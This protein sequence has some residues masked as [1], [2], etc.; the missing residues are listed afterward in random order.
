M[1]RYIASNQIGKC[2]SPNI[3]HTNRIKQRLERPDLK[4][5][6]GFKIFRAGYPFLGPRINK[7]GNLNLK[8]GETVQLESTDWSDNESTSR[9]TLKI[10][11]G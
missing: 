11:Y 1:F 5:F 6:Y 2:L 4:T 3:R 10:I 8:R 9:L 7:P